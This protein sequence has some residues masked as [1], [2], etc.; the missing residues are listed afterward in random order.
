VHIKELVL[1]VDY[2]AK[3][4]EG[5]VHPGTDRV[6]HPSGFVDLTVSTEARAE[7]VRCLN[8]QL[9]KQLNSL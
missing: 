5:Y 3:K 4:P 7:I 8:L 1:L 6:G 9:D 2:I